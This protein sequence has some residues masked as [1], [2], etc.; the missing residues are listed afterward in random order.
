M[1]R[2][3]K[4]SPVF[5][6]RRKSGKRFANKSVRKY[7]KKIQSGRA[8]KK[9]FCSYNI[10]DYS[11]RTTW[12]ERTRDLEAAGKAYLHGIGQDNPMNKKTFDKNWW[13]KFYRRK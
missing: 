5:K 1:S 12:E 11:F 2:S 3:Y 9:I 4:K 6:D 13:R 10:S 8:Y 7:S